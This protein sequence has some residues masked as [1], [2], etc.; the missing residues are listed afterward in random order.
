LRKRSVCP[1]RASP[2]MWRKNI[3]LS[4]AVGATGYHRGRQKTHRGDFTMVRRWHAVVLVAALL[5]LPVLAADAVENDPYSLSLGA[6][7]VTR[8]N[9]SIRLDSTT[10]GPISIGTSID[11][12]RDLGGET[13]M[14]VPRIDGYYRFAPKHRVD[15]SWYK[16]ERGGSVTTQRD[17]NFGGTFY[18]AGTAALTSQF[19]TST[20]KLSYTY[21]FYRTDEIETS[22]SAGLHVTK[23]D[24]SLQ[25]ASG[26]LAQSSSAT[27]PLPVFG[28]RLDY[29]LTPKWWMRGKYE[30][31]FLDSVDSFRGALNDFTLAI[32][33][34]TFQHIGFGFGLNRSSLDVEVEQTNY[35]GAL[36]TVLNGVMVYAVVR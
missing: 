2:A 7:F 31:F 21:S 15:F 24:V 19:D 5:P 22:V 10:G 28:F 29:A 17:I 25:T 8:T 16:I 33:H 4:L 11:W 13:S 18:P 6:Y 34:R 27:A 14:T 1:H 12:E 9:G 32:E 35:R 23:V 30:L 3:L 36:S 20:T 26:S